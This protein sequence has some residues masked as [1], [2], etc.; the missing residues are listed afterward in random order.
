MLKRNTVN[1]LCIRHAESTLN[2]RRHKLE[3]DPDYQHF[4]RLYDTDPTLAQI[5]SELLIRRYPMPHSDHDAPLTGSGQLQAIETGKALRTRVKKP[6]AIF[7]SPYHR[8]LA[9]MG[10]IYLGWPAL[11]SVPLVVDENLREQEFG[12]NYPWGDF[13]LFL[14][15]D[16]RQMELFA[17][18]GLYRYRFPQGENKPDTRHRAFHVVDRVTRQYRGKQVWFVGHFTQLL[19]VRAEL[20]DWDEPTYM[21]YHNGRVPNCSVSE[22]IVRAKPYPRMREVVR[23]AETFYE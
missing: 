20:E 4:L 3:A 6:D 17:S 10:G 16:A 11:T 23:Y 9:T 21:R 18:E 7:V 2:K 22:Y 19:S 5:Q 13:K 15:Q 1:L 8:A 12:G 14:V